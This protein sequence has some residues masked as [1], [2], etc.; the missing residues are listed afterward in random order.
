MTQKLTKAIAENDSLNEELLVIKKRFDEEHE[1]NVST[2][3]S[4]LMSCEIWE[5]VKLLIENSS[6][7]FIHRHFHVTSDLRQ[8]LE[9]PKC[10]WSEMKFAVNNLLRLH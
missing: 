9:P 4:N 10:C 8:I 2:G 5:N 6:I 1:E 7:V 3:V